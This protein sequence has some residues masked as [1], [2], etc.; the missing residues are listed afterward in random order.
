[1]TLVFTICSVNYLAQAH[2]F[3]DSLK[4]LNPEFEFVIGLVDKLETK[5]ID[6]T[7]LPCYTLLEV[8]KINIPDFEEMCDRYNITEL[9]TAVKPYYFDYF[10]KNRP[11]ITN[12]IYFDP[13]IIIFDKLTHL[14]DNLE[15]YNIVVTPH[16]TTPYNDNLWQSEEDLIN[17]GIYNFG[18]VGLKRSV[19]AQK[20]IKWWCEKLH[21]E[22]K[23]DL[24]NG[25][26]VDQHWAEFFPV[27]FDKVFIDKHLGNNVAYWN[28]HERFCSFEKNQWLINKTQPLQF[29]HYSGYLI[30]KPNE[31]SKY[32]NRINFEERVD[33]IPLF[34]LY[35]NRLLANNELYW[36]NFKCDY[37]K[38][39]KITRFVRVRKYAKLPLEKL[40][41]L[42]ES[43]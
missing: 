23:I 15:K 11:E 24:C 22:C 7:K 10:L 18:F 21:N 34:E 26:F 17:T 42:I 2:T 28:L 25:L 3:G 31:V 29:F 27:Y 20:M 4:T 35:K 1:M 19:E 38:P 30:A 6:K 43:L 14:Q 37:I 9:N 32:Q 5:S 12:I 36:K 41:S 33:I 40:A 39:P 16:I 13:D 8:D